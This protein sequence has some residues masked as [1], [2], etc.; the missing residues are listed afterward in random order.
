LISPV[1][2]TREIHPWGEDGAK[3]VQQ[4][5]AAKVPMCLAPFEKQNGSGIAMPSTSMSAAV[6]NLFVVEALAHPWPQVEA[7][8]RLAPFSMA[9]G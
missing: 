1:G 8:Q 6:L 9:T 3:P 4:L 7:N 5:H 2:Y